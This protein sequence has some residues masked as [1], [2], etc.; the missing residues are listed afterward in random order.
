MPPEPATPPCRHF[1]ACGGCTAQHI[2]PATQHAAKRERLRAALAQ[3]GFPAAPLAPLVAIPMGTRRRVDLAAMRVGG[4]LRLGFHAPRSRDV[5]DIAECPLAHPTIE[6]LIPKLRDLLARLAAFH[7]TGSV[8]VNLLDT[9]ADIAIT[10]DAPA[11]AADRAR[12]VAFA[13]EHDLPR[14]SLADEPV[15]LQ[16]PP[17]LHC[18]GLAVTIPPGAFLQPTTEGEA[19]IRAAVLAGLPPKLTRKS[20]IVELYAGIGTLT[21]PLAEAAR[22]HAVE[23][24]QPAI[25][26]LDAAARAAGLAGRITTET[27]DLARRPM[28]ARELSS[29]AAIV[30]DPPFDGAAPQ[31]RAI[32]ESKVKRIVYVS[33]NPD[34]L[35]RDATPL[36]RAGYDITA[37]TPID[38]FP[39]SPHLESVIVF[40]L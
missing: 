31:I 28:T 17:I 37:A 23:G 39:A 16:R 34:A 6:A 12:L 18:A 1:G 32:A 33:C 38:Q 21:G 27:R 3:A 11:T 8:L 30:L 14:I 36:R 24:N 5:V 22:I 20:Q 7:K 35:S 4:A 19:A 13:R 15:L 25:A 26:A 2:P 29:A 40:A 10:L 9:G